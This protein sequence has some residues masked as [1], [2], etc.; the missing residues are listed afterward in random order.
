MIEHD[1]RRKIMF[2]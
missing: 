2:L 1:E